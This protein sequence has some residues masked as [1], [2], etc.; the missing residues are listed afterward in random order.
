MMRKSLTLP[1]VILLLLAFGGCSD[2]NPG[3]N[4]WIAQGKQD[5]SQDNGAAARD[6]FEAARQIRPDD[7]TAIYGQL[8]AMIQE[9]FNLLTVTL[10][11]T[12][13]TFASPTAEVADLSTFP[14]EDFTSG[15][16]Q[17]F[18]FERAGEM[19][20]LVNELKTLENPEFVLDGQADPPQRLV[21]SLLDH[22]LLEI[23]GRFDLGEALFIEGFAHIARA[24]ADVNLALFL[25]FNLG[26]LDLEFPENPTQ[27]ELMTFIASNL[28]ALLTDP[29]CRP[30]A[31]RCERYPD[32]ICPLFFTIDDSLP[33]SEG[34]TGTDLV[35]RAKS[36]F[37]RAYNALLS[38]LESI[39]GE[40][41]KQTGEVVGYVDANQDG[42]WNVGEN[43]QGPNTG[44]F[45]LTGIE[46]GTTDVTGVTIYWDAMRSVFES[47]LPF[48]LAATNRLIADLLHLPYVVDIPA[49]CVTFDIASF[50]T[51][52]DPNFPRESLFLLSD[53][54]GSA[55]VATQESIQQTRLIVDFLRAN[56]AAQVLWKKQAEALQNTTAEN[57]DET[58]TSLSGVL[59][60]IIPVCDQI[61]PEETCALLA[62]VDDLLKQLQK[63]HTQDLVVILNS[64][65][66]ILLVQLEIYLRQPPSP[67]VPTIEEENAIKA[68]LTPILIDAVIPMVPALINIVADFPEEIVQILADS[69]LV[70]DELMEPLSCIIRG[71]DTSP[72]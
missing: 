5:L 18:V 64:T 50:F 16:L 17:F 15:L 49:G 40:T 42:V 25:D 72:R 41:H 67:Q 11:L 45:D 26:C 66:T 10:D 70:P 31:S 27:L 21:L 32:G 34:M 54:L 60:K 2:D 39:E 58:L 28:D 44:R 51:N 63:D 30:P 53:L 29:A 12:G 56:P 20:D 65:G 61:F 8:L 24:L 46:A 22:T 33:N 3:F 7:P 19:I 68:D 71:I 69:G 47:D 48:D 57:L 43:F 55:I 35:L 37:A 36:S 1:A 23:S 9:T 6:A 38:A 59:E 13:E 52:P 4:E 14:V 62:N